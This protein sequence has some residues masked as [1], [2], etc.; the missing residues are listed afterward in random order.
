[1]YENEERFVLSFVR[2]GRQERLLHELTNPKKRYR[3]LDRFCHQSS[4]L[5][6]PERV[7]IQGDDLMR[8]QAFVGFVAAHDEECVI[9]SPDPQLDGLAMPLAEAAELSAACADAS[10]VLG[11]DFA[12]VTGE[13]MKGG[14]ERYLLV[15]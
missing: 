5:V 1:M 7:L 10:I 3:G 8:G 14:R 4:E 12:I 9:L 13:A 15:V 6:D 2:R 11:S